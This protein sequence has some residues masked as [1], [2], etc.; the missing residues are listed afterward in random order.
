MTADEDVTWTVTKPVRKAMFKGEPSGLD[1]LEMIAPVLEGADSFEAAGLEALVGSWAE[2][3]CDGNLGRIAQ[4]LRIAATGGTVSPPIFDTLAILG[5]DA[6]C[7]RMRRCIEAHSGRPARRLPPEWRL[8]TGIVAGL[9]R[10][11]P[12]C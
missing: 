11:D 7:T 12:R 5:R 3:N 6:F 1:L 4:P 2:A 9:R 10:S 8:G